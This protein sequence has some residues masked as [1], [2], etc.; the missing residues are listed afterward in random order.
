MVIVSHRAIGEFCM[1]HPL[2]QNDLKKWY[3]E[4]TI[5]DW[6][7]FGDLKHA[8][9]SF[10]SA[11]DG[12]FVFNISVNN[13]RLIARIFFKKRTLFIRFVGLGKP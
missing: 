12:L 13:C 8:Y 6:S 7:N 9:N 10:D 11:G 5:A 3:H 4:T 1:I 2:Y